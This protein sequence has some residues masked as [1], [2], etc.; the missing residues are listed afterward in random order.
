MSLNA[1]LTRGTSGRMA[2]GRVVALGAS[3]D[4]NAKLVL[5]EVGPDGARQAV[6]LA[7]TPVAAE[8][9]EAERG[10]LLEMRT[11]CAGDPALLA[12]LP[13]P[14]SIRVW[15]GSPALVCTAVPGASL[16][17]AYHR[18]GHTARPAQVAE[19]LRLAGG[20]LARFHLATAAPEATTVC[21]GRD[22]L[23]RLEAR[24]DGD[25]RL[26]RVRGSL[27]DAAYQLASARVA[28][29][30]SHGD[31]WCGNVLVSDGRVSGVVDWECATGE[32]EPLRDLARF[33]LAYALYLDRHTR[34]GR[35]VRGHS[36]LR[37]GAPCGGLDYA[38]AGSGWFPELFAE[39]LG[40]GLA[41]CGADRDLWRALAL[42]GV[43]DVA[44]SAD[45]PAFAGDH[46]DCLTRLVEGAAP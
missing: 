46:L 4:P 21:F 33:A 31:F 40:E 7:T 44:G 30:A 11:R 26:D 24:F 39:F 32:G 41:R 9:L 16:A 10:A 45:S 15:N 6:K 17:T 14:L 13:E 2:A 8:A 3:K 20:W 42:V 34:G 19:D 18:R 5:V 37:A 35:E 23:A 1:F 12:T 38:I 22:V 28:R 25:A 43:A 27:A 36:G 29:T